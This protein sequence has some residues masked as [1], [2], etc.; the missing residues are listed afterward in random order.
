MKIR[1]HENFGE[2]QFDV[3]S[4]NDARLDSMQ[5]SMVQEAAKS[6]EVITCG[7]DVFEPLNDDAPGPKRGI[8]KFEPFQELTSDKS[9]GW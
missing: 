1:V 9:C 5:R 6:G 2:K 3:T 8:E 4:A 7:H